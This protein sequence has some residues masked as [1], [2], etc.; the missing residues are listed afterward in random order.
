MIAFALFS[1]L[2]T[3]NEM[4]FKFVITVIAAAMIGLL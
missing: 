3:I 1:F 2:L 4:E